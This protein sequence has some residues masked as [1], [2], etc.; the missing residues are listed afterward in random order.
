[1]QAARGREGRLRLPQPVG[2]LCDE[3]GRD[4]EAALDPR[5]LDGDRLERA[6]AADPAGGRRVEVPREA[7]E[8]EIPSTSTSTVFAPVRQGATPDT[9]RYAFRNRRTRAPVPRRGRGCA[10][11]RRSAGRR[12]GSRAAPRPRSRQARSPPGEAARPRR[13]DAEYGGTS[14]TMIANHRRPPAH[15][16]SSPAAEGADAPLGQPRAHPPR[17]RPGHPELS[18]ALADHMN[19]RRGEV[20]EVVSFYSFL[21]VPVDAVRVCIGPVCDCLGAKDLLAREQEKANGVP[22]LGVE[23]L[24]H[25]DIAPVLT[26]GDVVEPEVTRRTNT[27]SSLGLEQADETLADY[28][29]RGGLSVASQPAAQGED[30]R[31]A[32]GL[33]PL[34]LRGRRL[35][36]RPQVGGGREASRLRAT[37]WSTPTRASR[38][39][40]RTAT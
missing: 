22:V 15:R 32:Q 26:R 11:S 29:A 16:G 40:S 4:D 5:R 10:W 39:R 36:D 27:G 37:S 20:H 31:G 38:G 18:D 12:P 6:L 7:L 28:E 13:E 23:C 34:R 25:C 21:E 8:V 9:A 33:R 24:G 17:G 30:R 1:M 19:V 14:F 2:Q 35:P 3:L